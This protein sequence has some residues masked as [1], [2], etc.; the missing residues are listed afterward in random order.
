MGA[1]EKDLTKRA[2]IDSLR[3]TDEEWSRAGKFAD[4]LSVFDICFLILLSTL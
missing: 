4:L 2:K 1:Q 3:L